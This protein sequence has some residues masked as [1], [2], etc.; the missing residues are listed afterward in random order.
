MARSRK[1]RM[2]AKPEGSTYMRHIFQLAVPQHP[3]RLCSWLSSLARLAIV[4]RH[5]SLS[6][7]L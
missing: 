2:G 7:S 1:A 3:A 6:L 4:V 5:P